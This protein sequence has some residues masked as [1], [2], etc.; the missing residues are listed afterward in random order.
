MAENM[1]KFLRGNVA[2]LPQTATAGAVYFT[3]DEGL[4]LGLEDGTYHRYG[5]FI[6]VTDV[7]SL[8]EAGAHETCMYYCVAENILAKWNGTSWVQINKQKTLAE[9]GGVAKSVYEAKIAL[10]EKADADNATAIAELT[11]YVGTIP[12]GAT[13]TNVVAYIQEKTAGI[14]TSSSLE[15]LA[16]RVTTVEGEIDS[17][18]A[19]LAEGGDT[20]KAISAAQSAAD[21]AQSDVDALELKIGTVEEGKTVVGLIDEASAAASNAQTAADNA[22]SDVNAL[23]GKVGEV[24]EGSTV[25]GLIEAAQAQA[26]KG[27]ADAAT[28]QAAADKAQGE[29][30]A[31]EGVVSEYKTANDAAVEAAQKAADDA[32]E[33]AASKATMNEVN[34]AIANAGH[35]VQSEVDQAIADLDAAYKKADGDLKTE[36]EG[37]IDEKVS[38]TAYDTKIGEL[39]AEDERLAGLV[40]DNADAIAAEKERAE[41]AEAGL[42][43]QIN[44]IM[45]NP[46]TEGVINSINEFTQYIAD[47]GEIA[48]GFRTDIDANTKAISDHEAI[49]AQTY[50]IK[51]DAAQKLVD[52]KAYTDEQIAAIPAT[53]WNDLTDKPFGEI[54][55]EGEVILSETTF[56]GTETTNIALD[57]PYSISKHYRDTIVVEFDGVTYT[58]S[59]S[60]QYMGGSDAYWVGNADLDSTYASYLSGDEAWPFCILQETTDTDHIRVSASTDGEHTIKMYVAEMTTKTIDEKYIPD[61]IARAD[62]VDTL[63]GRVDVLEEASATHAL[64]TEVE[65]V[66][67]ALDEYKESND[68]E[69][70]LKADASVVEAMDEAYKAADDALSARIEKLENNEADYATTT[71]VATAKSEAIAAAK[72]ETE[73]QVNAL[74][75]GAVADNAAAIA[76]KAAQADLNAAV[77]RVETAEGKIADLETASAT[78]A[79][80]TEVEAVNTALTEY[81]TSNDEAVA[82]KANAADVY[83]KTE[84][85]TKAEV[86]AAVSAGVTAATTWGEF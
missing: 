21:A 13:A 68:A 3:K 59:M 75:N 84:T 58:P 77:A 60:T 6:T 35:A 51:D 28:A 44:T 36:L 64:K 15:E 20:A 45:N 22:Q 82:S 7:A 5:D 18:L 43:T 48:E 80:K 14:A 54:F 26:D 27:V 25:V 49:A 50:E 61:T 42:Q 41:A 81:K 69:V 65:D 12:E 72:T 38:Q 56:T 10:L 74:A 4:Y 29:V 1:I 52:A 86:D 46:D 39:V 8:P 67:T 76:T 79:L 55:G 53:S 62:A 78:H 30:D 73:T 70:A 40:S 34:D 37:K 23:A 2:S 66:Q 19:T 11:T 83:A 9:L 16:G 32:A 24:A 71:E 33:L 17:L 63:T 31:L 47:H 57:S 85:Y